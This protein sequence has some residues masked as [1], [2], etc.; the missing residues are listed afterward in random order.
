R[1]ET[2][3]VKRC[4]SNLP[5]APSR[6]VGTQKLIDIHQ[7]PNAPSEGEEQ[8][9]QNRYQS[10]SQDDPSE[11]MNKKLIGDQSSLPKI[12]QEGRKQKL[13][14]YQSNLTQSPSE[15]RNKKSIDINQL[16]NAP[17]EV[18][19]QKVKAIQS[20]SPMLHSEEIHPLLNVKKPT[21]K[22]QQKKVSRTNKG[23][24]SKSEKSK[25]KYRSDEI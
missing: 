25:H 2:K 7:P 19:E 4:Q 20:T 15:G 6:K 8:K 12:H 13:I 3:S 21:D 22:N 14:D 10:T 11:G 9:V 16:P 5:N 24:P 23:K 17:S 18:S 1:E